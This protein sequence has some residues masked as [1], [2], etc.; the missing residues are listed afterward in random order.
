MSNLIEGLTQEQKQELYALLK[1]IDSLHKF[2]LPRKRIILFFES[3]K[4]SPPEKLW[5]YLVWLRHKELAHIELVVNNFS[6]SDSYI[7]IDEY[8]DSALQYSMPTRYGDK[9]YYFDEREIK[10]VRLTILS[11]KKF[12]NQVAKLIE[13]LKTLRD[14][15]EKK[16]TL[17][18]WKKVKRYFAK[19]QIWLIPA[20]VGF[21]GS[22]VGPL[23]VFVVQKKLGD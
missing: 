5:D 18:W 17:P 7:N 10:G 2:P 1:H 21:I 22:I 16:A 15:A 4:T 12:N 3:Y 23:I 13:G 11:Q 8:S 9:L 14:T 20:I 19:H 6:R